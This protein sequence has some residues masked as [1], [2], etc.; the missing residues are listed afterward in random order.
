[1]GVPM[2]PAPA[3][4]APVGGALQAGPEEVPDGGGGAALAWDQLVLDAGPGLGVLAG[5]GEG[6]GVLTCDQPALGDGL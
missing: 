1:M 3:G 4:G 5:G 2:G 6:G